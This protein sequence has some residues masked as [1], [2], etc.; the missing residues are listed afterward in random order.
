MTADRRLASIAAALIALDLL[1][2][3]VAM[4]QG[5]VG[6]PLRLR[7][8]LGVPASVV[9]V[10]WGT[11]V[12]APWGMDALLVGLLAGDDPDRARR[13]ARALAAL[14]VAGVL[15]E[16]VTWGRRRPRWAMALSAAHLGLGAALL[17]A[18]RPA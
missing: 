15:A 16:P 6:E 8:A 13:G 1:G 9:L 14:R 11:A 12:S 10:G 5:L 7:L 17:R 3:R 4:W 18:A 2:A